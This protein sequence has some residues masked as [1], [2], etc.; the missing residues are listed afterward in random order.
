MTLKG[1]CYLLNLVD[2]QAHIGAYIAYSI[3]HSSN[4]CMQR[5]GTTVAGAAVGVVSALNLACTELAN[6]L[7]SHESSFHRVC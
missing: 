5:Q 2:A 6:N 3:H 7:L 4:F 1:P